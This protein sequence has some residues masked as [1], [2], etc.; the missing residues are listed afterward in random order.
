MTVFRLLNWMLLA[1]LAVPAFAD[2][3]KCVDADGH[4][5]YSNIQIK[6][7]K[8]LNLTPTNAMPAP[9]AKPAPKVGSSTVVGP[10]PS[11][12]GFP[13]VSEGAQKSRDSDRRLILEQEMASEQRGLEQ[14]R[15]ELSAQE[16]L[17][18]ANPDR[19][20]PYKDRI[21]QHERN[22]QALNKEIAGLR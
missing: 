22:I 10:A 20:A 3:Y 11:P 12:A 6:G 1:V 5:T 21:A 16:A 17:P 9:V 7:C 8:N 15:R 14:A 18:G 2:V 13:K 19:L 4:V